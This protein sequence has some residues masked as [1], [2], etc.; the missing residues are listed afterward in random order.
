MR[1]PTLL[2]VANRIGWFI[3][4]PCTGIGAGYVVGH[5]LKADLLPSLQR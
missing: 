2:D 5:V 3:I 1:R 4:I